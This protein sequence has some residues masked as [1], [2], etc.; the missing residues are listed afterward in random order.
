MSGVSASGA[1]AAEQP[2]ELHA[3]K[4]GSSI[5]PPASIR[6]CVAPTGLKRSRR[7]ADRGLTPT[8]IIVSSL[9]DLPRLAMQAIMGECFVNRRVTTEAAKQWRVHRSLT[10][11]LKE[12]AAMISPR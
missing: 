5:W 12:F 11:T 10:P 8:A 9:R 6:N 3:K 1:P 7:I 4:N 2:H